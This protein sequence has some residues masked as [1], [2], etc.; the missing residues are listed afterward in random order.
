MNKITTYEELLRER[1]RLELQLQV[2]EAAVKIHVD[3]I[4]KK[5]S[6]LRNLAHFFSNFTAPMASDTL[7]G[8]GLGLTLELLI[9]NVLFARTGWI[10]KMVAPILIKNFSA[11]M[12]QKNK[13]SLI[14]KVKSFLHLDGKPS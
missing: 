4:K 7:I 8:T 12:L 13:L 2:H 3:D 11:N 1:E 5:L 10:T 9:R 6:P 14:R